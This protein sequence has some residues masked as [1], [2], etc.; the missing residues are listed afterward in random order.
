MQVDEQRL[1]ADI[2]KN[3]SFG[4]IEADG[5][6]RTVLAG[7][8][9]NGAARDYF[10]E[11]LEDAGLDVKVDAVGNIVGRWVSETADPD[12]DAIAAGS[13]LD[14]VR[15]GG[16][17]DGPLGVY[18]ALESVRALQE[19]GVEVQRPVEVVC[20]TEEEGQRFGNLLGSSVASGHTSVED[21][22]AFTDDDDVTLAEGLEEIGY[23]G[24]GR[25]DA[26][27]W[28]AYIEL[29]IEQ[30]RRL[31]SAGVPVGIVTGITGITQAIVNIQGEAD[32]A[33]TTS[34]N[35]R[36]DALAAASEFV[37]DIERA[38][39]QVVETESESAVGTVGRE[40]VRPNSTNV[41]PG[42]V[43]LGVDIRDIESDSIE[44]IISEA[45]ESLQRL[46]DE[47]NVDTSYITDL[48]ID[49]I[50][51]SERCR[52]AMQQAADVV[53]LDVPELSSGAG[54]DPMRI[55]TAT[56]VGMLFARSKDGISHNP[57]EWTSWSDCASATRVLGESIAILA[58]D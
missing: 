18:A 20:F 17:F 12:A 3:A 5:H 25:V 51:M 39:N 50:P 8:P 22:L 15:E 43:T 13:H 41:I 32:H 27:E 7:T 16:I 57:K 33:G 14:S 48:D 11:R 36:T 35:H 44:K 42:Q 29:H 9:P 4:A 34:M 21:A 30:G 58:S 37:L 19:G 1:R 2:E 31:E 24:E 38:A 47:R 46:E 56:D 55:A 23:A 6:G 26:E 10:V 28:D 45:K 54:H 53:E 49:P 52:T 40:V